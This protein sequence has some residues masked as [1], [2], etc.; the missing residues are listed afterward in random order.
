VYFQGKED[1]MDM[2]FTYLLIRVESFEFLLTTDDPLDYTYPIGGRIF[3]I[4]DENE[5]LVGKFRLLYIDIASAID[6]R[7]T[8]IF[9][10]FDAYSAT[11]ADYYSSTFE[12]DEM[13]FS[14]DL[15]QL[16]VDDIYEPNLL[17]F[18]RLE[19]LPDYRGHNLGIAI[20]R[21]LIQRFSAGAG[22]VGIKPFPLQFEF[23]IP[24]DDEDGWHEEMQ[25][26]IFPDPERDAVRKLK[27]HYGKLGFV[28]MKGT[29]HMFLSTS[30]R[31][32]SIEK[33]LS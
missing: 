24:A 5:V 18:D 26:S 32:P 2:E 1:K 17:I 30:R 12:S 4:D 14:G 16:L 3:K 23:S 25:L 9:Q 15:R 29:P 6:A 22:V 33:L 10:I 11:T 8:D 19:L 21:R 7:F 20:M 13:D 27:D 31:L 28:E